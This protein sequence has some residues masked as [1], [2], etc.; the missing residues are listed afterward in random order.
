MNRLLSISLI[1]A[2][3]GTIPARAQL[4]I[5]KNGMSDVWERQFNDGQLF[6]DSFIAENDDDGD[7]RTNLEESIA[8]TDPNSGHPPEGFLAKEVRHVPAT[9]FIDPEEEEPVLLTPEAYEID[10]PGVLGKR[11]VLLVSQDLTLESWIPVGEPIIGDGEIISVG[12]NPTLV[13]GQPAEKLFWR[14]AVTDIDSDGD[15]LFDHEEHVLGTNP[16]NPET[17][18]GFGDLWMATNFPEVLPSGLLAAMDSDG[19]GLTNE[20]EQELGTD[21]HVADNPGILQ[22]ALVNGD[23]SEPVIGTGTRAGAT[24]IDWDYW[25]GANVNGW[26]AVVGENI[27][28]Q[29]IDPMESGNQYVELK[30]HPMGHYGIKQRF[31]TRKGSQYLLIFEA[32]AR[33]NTPLY[34]NSILIQLNGDTIQSIDFQDY[35]LWE[36]HLVLFTADTTISEIKL[37]PASPGNTSGCLVDNL[38]IVS[39]KLEIITPD[40]D[41]WIQPLLEEQVILRDEVAKIK[42]I[43][44]G[45]NV[46]L[47]EL[48]DS[49]NGEIALNTS[50]TRLGFPDLNLPLDD[51]SCDFLHG[52]NVTEVR[53][54]L[55][56]LDLQRLN[57][58][59]S[60][61]DP[62]MTTHSALDFVDGPLSNFEDSQAFID[63]FSA[64]FGP[65]SGYS[66]NK[67]GVSLNSSPPQSMPHKSFA[68][69]AGVEI[70]SVTYAGIREKCMIMNQG[71]IFYYSG[72][73][74]PGTRDLGPYIMISD[75]DQVDGIDLKEYWDEDL[76]I[77][78]FAGCS[79]VNINN[80][81][82]NPA[83][84]PALTGPDAGYYPGEFMNT[85]GPRYILGYGS[86][87]PRDNGQNSAQIAADFT[88][89]YQTNPNN[90]FLHWANANDNTNGRNATALEK[91]IKF[92]YFERIEFLGA[93]VDYVWTTK[94]VMDW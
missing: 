10:W 86:G 70:L 81:N 56:L 65:P 31:G 47:F 67:V 88:S 14:V 21:P 77:V 80:W 25:P 13:G 83:F 35:G 16:N 5:N 30:A 61:G 72:H 45:D 12:M 49:G 33:V 44:K 55:N 91:N 73:G 1:L 52:E 19:D 75:G 63:G 66:N 54:A 76:N 41:S 69:A 40:D 84:Y 48:E 9:W 51:D 6:P 34:D 87:A 26:T 74:Y 93:T 24:N 11:Y 59:P 92:G 62:D 2:C 58:L 38:S 27:E 64:Y 68:A 29:I 71:E 22:D 39:I 3:L 23:F 60:I 57:L 89:N 42:I 4:D 36:R 8:G 79:L 20:Q 28:Y 94:N 78:I 85:I 37:T 17:M 90:P 53:I 7:G 50:V 32:K 18:P 15:G 82:P 46:S 43:F